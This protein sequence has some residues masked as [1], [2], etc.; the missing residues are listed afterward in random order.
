MAKQRRSHARPMLLAILVLLFPLL[1]ACGGAAPATQSPTAGGAAQPTA[2]PQAEAAPTAAPEAPAEQPTPEGPLPQPTLVPAPNAVVLNYWDMQWG[3][4]AFMNQLQDNVTEFNRTH[5]EIFVNFQQLSWGDYNQKLLSAVQAGNPPDIG[6]GDSGIP[7]NM[8]AQ[9]QALDI[10]DLYQE[11][12]GDGTFDDMVPW[13]YEK[14]DYNGKRPGVT[15]QFDIRAIFYRKDMFEKAGIS[16]PTTWEELLAAA[17]KLTAAD[18]SVI[19]IAVPGKQ[20]SYDTDQF[21]M[22]LVLQAG[23]GLA[24]AEGNPTFDTPEQLKAL[25][26]EKQLVECCAA[27]GTPSWTFT[28]VMK[29]FEQGQAAMAFGGGWFAGDIKRNAPDILDKTGVL[30]VLIGPGGPQAQHS[31]AFANP[32]MIYKQTKHAAEAKIFLK[33]MMK[34]ENLLKLYASDPG[35]KW[36]VYKSM[37][38]DPIYKDNELV[39]T[40][41]KQV[42]ETGV[43]YWYPNNKAAVGIGSMGT[44]IADIIVN[45]VISGQRQPA[46]V[47]KDAQEQIGQVFVKQP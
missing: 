38:N 14:W 24:D 6:G 22:T 7:F 25:E 20:G 35:G 27:P 41:A 45:P 19:G 42:V 3:G 46:E 12:Q 5:P 31:V 16:V 1:A 40:L 15:W 26:F 32:W 2:A 44:G 28:E 23:G 17:K 8:D 4:P 18:K 21:Y 47:L 10:T 39:Q 13:A 9:G 33:W 34:K 11:W 43:D 29:A 30:P 37:L 36:P